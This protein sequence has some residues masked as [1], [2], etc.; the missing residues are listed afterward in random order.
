MIVLA[1]QQI[2]VSII[3]D[4]GENFVSLPSQN[5]IDYAERT[6]SKVFKLYIASR[7]Y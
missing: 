3:W 4:Y 1:H 5:N 2:P 6:I 7:V